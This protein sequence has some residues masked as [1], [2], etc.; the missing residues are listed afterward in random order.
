[1]TL[2]FSDGSSRT[3]RVVFIVAPN[4]P[5]S[6]GRLNAD[7]ATAAACPSL[8]KVVFTELSAG[9]AVSVGYPGQVTVKAVDDCGTPLTSGNV[10]ASSTNRRSRP[11]TC[12][13]R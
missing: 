12:A 13:A 11:R 10:V 2:S 1:M 3:V 6:G 8:L 9:S 7:A 4:N 5:M